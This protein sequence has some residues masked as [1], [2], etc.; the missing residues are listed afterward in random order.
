MPNPLIAVVILGVLATGASI[1][2]VVAT[3]HQGEHSHPFADDSPDGSHRTPMSGVLARATRSTDYGPEPQTVQFISPP[4]SAPV[5]FLSGPFDPPVN[6][7][8]MTISTRYA[9]DRFEADM[10]QI[11]LGIESIIL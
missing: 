1:G 3:R 10:Q 6:G 8:A 4:V 11:I 5:L 2:T 9:I 7:A